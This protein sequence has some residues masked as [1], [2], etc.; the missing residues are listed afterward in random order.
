MILL[1]TRTC[2]T[3]RELRLIRSGPEP[4]QVDDWFKLY[5]KQLSVEIYAAVLF[6]HRLQ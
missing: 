3:G 5:N 1:Q 2:L 6:N 4:C